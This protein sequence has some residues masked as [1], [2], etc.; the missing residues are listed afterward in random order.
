MNFTTE[1][2]DVN[3][4][5]TYV[6]PYNMLTVEERMTSCGGEYV[7][8]AMG[9]FHNKKYSAQ[10]LQAYHNYL[11]NNAPLLDSDLL[12]I[13]IALANFESSHVPKFVYDTLNRLA[14]MSECI[15]GAP[16]TETSIKVLEYLYDYNVYEYCG[17]EF[18]LLRKASQC[19]IWAEIWD[20]VSELSSEEMEILDTAILKYMEPKNDISMFMVRMGG[21]E[22]A[23]PHFNGY[24][25]VPEKHP[26]Y[27]KH[28]EDIKAVVHGGLTYVAAG[29]DFKSDV[30]AIQLTEYIPTAKDW[31]IGFDTMHAGDNEKTQNYRYVEAQC[32][33]LRAQAIEAWVDMPDCFK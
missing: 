15:N 24:I 9:A 8:D 3:G 19:V 22:Y 23:N 20:F 6:V 5:R 33:K 2:I 18:P 21:D 4:K 13:H 27:K 7:R 29:D 30:L 32:R 28:Y 11:N 10:I 16:S 31:V 12:R 26:W 1:T 17:T 14:F 25:S